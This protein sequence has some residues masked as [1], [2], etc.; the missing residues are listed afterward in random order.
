MPTEPARAR[1]W[2]AQRTLQFMYNDE[3]SALC[4]NIPETP[5][6]ALIR[7][8]FRRKSHD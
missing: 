7:E 8:H 2:Y 5:P 3:R 1:L 4:V 6:H